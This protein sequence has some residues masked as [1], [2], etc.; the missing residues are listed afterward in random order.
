M[1]QVVAKTFF[2]LVFAM[3]TNSP[4]KAKQGKRYEPLIRLLNMMSMVLLCD[5]L[6]MLQVVAKTFFELVLCR[7]H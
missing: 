7:G 2:K 5:C 1:V 3:A 4:S 6:S